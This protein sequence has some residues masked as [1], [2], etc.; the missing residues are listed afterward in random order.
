MRDRKTQTSSARRRLSLLLEAKN[1]VSLDEVSRRAATAAPRDGSK[2]ALIIELLRRADG[3][4][5]V[6]LTEATGWLAH[7]TRAAITGLRKRGSAVTRERTGA[8]DSIYRISGAPG[9]SG[10]RV[11]VQTKKVKGRR[12]A[13]PKTERAV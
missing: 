12:D 1:G 4:T 2:L 13:K 7:T 3:A 8:G 11:A 10:D 6:D 5:I 9:G